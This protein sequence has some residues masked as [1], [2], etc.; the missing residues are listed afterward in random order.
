MQVHRQAARAGR[1]GSRPARRAVKWCCNVMMFAV[2][3]W[4][5][6]RATAA[7]AAPVVGLGHG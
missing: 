4:L 2:L 1:E 3:A 5:D 6:D 7:G